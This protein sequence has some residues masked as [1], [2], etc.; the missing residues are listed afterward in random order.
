[1]QGLYTVLSQFD[2]TYDVILFV[3]F[4]FVEEPQEFH[5]YIGPLN[6]AISMGIFIQKRPVGH[7]LSPV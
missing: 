7:G 1:M 2:D 3:Q 6:S 4:D 5:D